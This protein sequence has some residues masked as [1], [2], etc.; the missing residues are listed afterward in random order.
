M[1]A[2]ALEGVSMA[3]GKSMFY[4][5][6]ADDTGLCFN[7]TERNFKTTAIAIKVF[8]IISGALLNIRK[9]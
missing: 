4:Q 1:L 2:G 8:E 3:G 7:G 6:F 9:S 5:L